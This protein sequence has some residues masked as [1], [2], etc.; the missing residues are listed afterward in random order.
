M[1]LL[2]DP[3]TKKLAKLINRMEVYLPQTMWKSV[4]MVQA[5]L[6]L[7]GKVKPSRGTRNT[8]MAG[9]IRF[10]VKEGLKN[11]SLGSSR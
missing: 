5:E 10:L 11:Y 9:T 3:L 8:A 7:S 2:Q 6:I 1:F 4:R